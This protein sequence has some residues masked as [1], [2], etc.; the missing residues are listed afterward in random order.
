MS[1]ASWLTHTVTLILAG[2]G[3]LLLLCALEILLRSLAE[4]GNVRFQ[5]TLEDHPR[6]FRIGREGALHVSVMLDALRWLQMASLALLWIVILVVSSDYRTYGCI[7]CLLLPILVILLIRG[8]VGGLGEKA[9]VRLL[10]LVRPLLWPVLFVIHRSGFAAGVS[11]AEDE[12][13]EAS[14]REIQAFV[15]VG[16]AAGLFE[17]DEGEIVESLVDFFDT[18]VREVMTPRT[19]MVALPATADSDELLRVFIGTQKSRVPIYSESIDKI[20]GVV[21]VKNL[22]KHMVEDEHPALSD[23]AHDCIVVPESK[24]LGDLLKDFQDQRQQM[25]IVVD[26]YGGTSGLVTLEDILE[27][28]VGDIVDEHDPEEPPDCQEVGPGLFQLLGRADVEVLEDLFQIEVNEEGVETVGGLV[29]ARH[30]TVPEAGTEVLDEAHG[31][32]FTVEEMDG[33]RIVS[34]KVQRTRPG[35]DPGV[36]GSD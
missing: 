35:D 27:E 26:E 5:G 7:L 21:H 1:V 4:I 2:V 15:D 25:A 18:T 33:N 17:R 29:F 31:L 14:E 28:I 23:L 24:E 9:V 34:V 30:G 22:V 13:E 19:D 36:T 20:V 16:Q 8:L 32:L 10:R 3:L 11:P 6:L 12:E